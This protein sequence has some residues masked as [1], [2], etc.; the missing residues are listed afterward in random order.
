MEEDIFILELN[1]ILKS[2]A[3]LPDKKY[4][5]NESSYREAYFMNDSDEY[6]DE[7]YI[8]DVLNKADEEVD[9]NVEEDQE[10]G[11]IIGTQAFHV[12]LVI[13]DVYYQHISNNIYLL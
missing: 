11:S 10:K 2:K 6:V 8:D 4:G 3:K 9:T 12:N 5:D 7:D 1:V 13:E